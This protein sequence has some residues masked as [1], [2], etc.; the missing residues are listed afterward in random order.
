MRMTAASR[1]E[2]ARL[3]LAEAHRA[4]GLA[5]R[6]AE[7]R[8]TVDRVLPTGLEAI[9]EALGG[10]LARGALYALSGEPGSGRASLA[11]AWLWRATALAR[12]PVAFI[13]GA[14]ALDPESVQEP[15]R[16]RMLWVRARSD[17]EALSCAE[18]VLDAGGFAMVCLYLVGA[19]RAAR[20]GTTPAR[21][22]SGHWTRLLQRA[23]ASR[24]VVLCVGDREDPRAPGGLARAS[25]VARRRSSRWGRS[26]VLDGLEVALSIDRNRRGVDAREANGRA[27][28]VDLVVA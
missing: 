13:D 15:L 22:G 2:Q 18:Q 20:G 25:L 7:H 17:L 23:E 21:V 11:L 9:D 6:P 24:A 26:D 12:E 5:R 16:R 19:A 27:V 10:G 3:A 4:A 1:V 28:L 8:S 14:D